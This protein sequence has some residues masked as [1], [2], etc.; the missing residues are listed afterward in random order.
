MLR[1]HN[2]KKKPSPLDL[3]QLRA[4]FFDL[5][6][7]LIDVDMA[8]F[9]PAYLSRLSACLAAHADPRRIS[10]TLLSAVREMLDGNNGPQTLEAFLQDRLAGQLGLSWSDYQSGLM[11]FCTTKL[12]E[13]RP[14]VRPHP[15]SR[16]L[17][18]SCLARGWQ[19]VLATN[20]IFPLQV[21]QA[22][23][24][25]GGLADIPFRVVTGYENCSYCKPHQ[26]FFSSL[27]EQL[28]LPPSACL[29]VGNDTLHDMAAGRCGMPTCLLTTWL[30]DRPGGTFPASWEGPHQALLE[31][32]E[33]G[34]TT[35]HND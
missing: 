16:P 30:I 4:V 29:M 2:R 15:L 33:T 18:E 1:F 27:Y 6:G 34:E 28:A 3:D 12:E 8:L 19:V 9:V 25:W 13:L 7:T 24:D 32:F 31:L 5:D 21:V 22:R 23:L 11:E 14:L 10:A 20:P 17:L 35:P 26:G